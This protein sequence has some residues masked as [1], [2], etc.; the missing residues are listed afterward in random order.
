MYTEVRK[1]D[2]ARLAAWHA[3]RCANKDR[4]KDARE[5]DPFL[6]AE[7]LVHENTLQRERRRLIQA[8]REDDLA[9]KATLPSR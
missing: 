8:E 3:M 2:P 6:H 9:T 4:Y 5:Q 7:Y 1:A